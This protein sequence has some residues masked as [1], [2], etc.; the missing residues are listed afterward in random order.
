MN[1]LA[2]VWKLP[3]NKY[4]NIYFEWWQEVWRKITQMCWW[5][6]HKLES[7]EK[8]KPQSKMPPSAVLWT[9]LWDIFFINS[10]WG[11]G[12]THFRWCYPWESN[13][14]LYTEENSMSYEEQASKQHFSILLRPLFQFLPLRSCLGSLPWLHDRQNKQFFF[15]N[16]VAFSQCFDH[17]NRNQSRVAVKVFGLSKTDRNFNSKGEEPEKPSVEKQYWSPTLRWVFKW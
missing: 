11:K 12:P 10:W 2:H 6:W 3:L 4:K 13:P 9:S 15:L 8:R 7:S 14:D 5:T 17:T 1:F 16:Q